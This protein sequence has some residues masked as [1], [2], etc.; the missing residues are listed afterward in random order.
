[1]LSTEVVGSASDEGTN[2][3][4]PET[5]CLLAPAHIALFRWFHIT[6]VNMHLCFRCSWIPAKGIADLGCQLPSFAPLY[7][8]DNYSPQ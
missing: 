1:M 7:Q 3:S 5:F 8:F 6:M 2:S 4:A